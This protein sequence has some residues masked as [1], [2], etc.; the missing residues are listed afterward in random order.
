MH[1]VRRIK[2]R[3]V[4]TRS[5]DDLLADTDPEAIRSALNLQDGDVAF[6]A[7]RTRI[8]EVKLIFF[9]FTYLHTH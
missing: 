9:V 1:T 3:T 8:P 2:G 5:T 4:A 6:L 7:R